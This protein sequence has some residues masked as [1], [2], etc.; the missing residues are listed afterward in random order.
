MSET[1]AQDTEATAHPNCSEARQF[2]SRLSGARGVD[3]VLLVSRS[4]PGPEGAGLGPGSPFHWPKCAC[5]SPKCPDY[6]AH[7][8]A[9]Q[10]EMRARVAEVNRRS[11]RGGP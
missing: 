8:P 1:K 11:R 3:G 5:G 2:L 7:P 9:T 10:E 6:Q 4:D